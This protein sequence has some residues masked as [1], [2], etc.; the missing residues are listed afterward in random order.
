MAY[1]F[2]TP[3]R[4]ADAAMRRG[5]REDL[6]EIADIRDPDLRDKAVEAWAYALSCSSFARIIDVPPEGNPGLS[7][8]KRGTQADHLRGV[9]HLALRIAE[10]FKTTRPE[11]GDRPRHRA[12]RG[13]LP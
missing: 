5:I 6:P 12:D 13:A 1:H 10:E 8:L 9:A 3:R 4:Q 2:V 11:C 7:V